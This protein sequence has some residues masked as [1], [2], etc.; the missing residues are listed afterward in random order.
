MLKKIYA[1]SLSFK[2]ARSF[3]DSK[4]SQKRATT[5]LIKKRM[6]E[7]K[8]NLSLEVYKNNEHTDDVIRHDRD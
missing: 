3:N 4:L 5:K 7:R 2:I 8:K 6:A 1:A